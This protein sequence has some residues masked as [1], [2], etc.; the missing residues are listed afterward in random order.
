MPTIDIDRDTARKAAQQELA[1]AIY[2]KQSPVQRFHDWGDELLYR[3]IQKGASIPGGWFAITVL[4]VMLVI[5]VMVALHAIRRS[6]RTTPD[7]QLLDTTQ[8]SADQ[9]RIAAENY[10]ATGNWA[11]AIR[12]RMRAV[13]RQLEESGVI[14]PAAGRT[15]IEL[16]QDA[17]AS[18]PHLAH[19]LYQAATIFNDAAYG[20]CP[21]TL[22]AYRL[23]VDLDDQ[24]RSRSSTGPS[25]GARA[26]ALTSWTPI[27]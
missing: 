18:L 4:V 27:R 19:E 16:A 26:E 24:L 10:A 12:H 20:E 23:I 25:G 7:R 17:A 21:G 9:H 22:A 1:K 15:A 11:T 2:P 13:A 5:A 14:N 3:L 6:M 8:L